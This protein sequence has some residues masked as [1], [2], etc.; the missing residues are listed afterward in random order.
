[1][2]Q[3]PHQPPRQAQAL[4]QP[5]GTGLFLNLFAAPHSAALRL[6]LSISR[7]G[8]L[9][10]FF[11]LSLQKNVQKPVSSFSY[12]FDALIQAEKAASDVA[13]AVRRSET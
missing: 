11:R 9:N 1:L 5:S 10:A 12:Y 13:N 3:L 8:L 2:P 4:F 6:R 7:D